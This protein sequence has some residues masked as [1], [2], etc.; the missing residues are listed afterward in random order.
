M[1]SN[2]KKATPFRKVHVLDF[3]LKVVLTDVRGNATMQCL[4]CLY[5]GRDVIEVDV[6]GWKRKQ[7]SDI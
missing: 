1:A 3:A 2:K 4:F 5:E 7:H 6:V